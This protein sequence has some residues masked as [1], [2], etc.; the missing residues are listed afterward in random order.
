M[1]GKG[2]QGKGKGLSSLAPLGQRCECKAH[3]KNELPCRQHLPHAQGTSPVLSVLAALPRQWPGLWHVARFLLGNLL[4]FC[5]G[6]T[7]HLPRF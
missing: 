2:S 5:L 6:L 1:Q 4:G 7:P 3:S